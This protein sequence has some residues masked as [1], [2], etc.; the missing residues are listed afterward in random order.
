MW[1]FF[2]KYISQ[3]K[4]QLSVNYRKWEIVYFKKSLDQMILDQ[5]TK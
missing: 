2:V 4:I 1:V 5:A 3:V